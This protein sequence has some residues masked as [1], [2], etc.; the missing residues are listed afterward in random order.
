MT[1]HPITGPI[2]SGP[3]QQPFVCTTARAGLGQPLVD[4]Q[5]AIGI[6]VAEEDAGG[7]YPQGGHGY[8]TE[9]AVIVG[10][11]K[12][13]SAETLIEYVY[14]TTAGAWMPLADPSASLPA[15]IATT[16]TMDGDTVPYIVR[17]ERGTINRFIYSL[18][19][20]APTTETDPWDPD[21]SLWN[22]KLIY[23]FQGGVAIG[24]TQGTTSGSRMLYDNGLSLGYAIV[25]S[26]GTKAGTHYNLQ[27]GGETAL[28][29][30]EHFIETHGVPEYTVGVGGSG[31]AIQQAVANVVLILEHAIYSVISPEGCASILWRDASKAEEAANALKL[32]AQDLESMGLV[33][34]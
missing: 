31:G 1:N 13:C 15:D 14:R 10:W 32:T 11:S 30:K 9:D 34:G 33:D 7:N 20:L 5:D 28:M 2:F 18:A 19:M 21:Q 4:N 12:D 8:P 23:H 26:T 17:W 24:H 29:V 16:E 22:G 27:V 6:P 3:Q 25:Y